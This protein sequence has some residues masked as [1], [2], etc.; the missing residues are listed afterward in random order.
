M[1]FILLGPPGSGK[2]TQGEYL[3]KKLNIARLSTGDL[4]RDEVHNKTEIGRKVQDLMEAGK[5]ASDDIVIGLVK[6]KIHSVKDKGFILDGFP[7]NVI[8]AKQLDS[9]LKDEGIA[10]DFV[11]NF[12]VE[13]DAVVKRISSR[14]FCEKCRATYNKIYKNPKKEGV[15]DNCGSTKFQ[16]RAD[17]KEDV[18]R[19]RFQDYN[20][21]T[22]PLVKHYS[23]KGNLHNI[24]ASGDV[25]DV[26]EKIDS[27]MLKSN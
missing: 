2:G 3:E 22:L 23:E 18:V 11:L 1:N 17:D 14:Y 19:K 27:L 5:F 13:E 10:I 8:Q 21:K 15:C 25:K 16:T 7:R 6:N 4:L 12:V 26:G 9:I 24:D 20:E